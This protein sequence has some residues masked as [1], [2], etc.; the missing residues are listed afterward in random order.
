MATKRKSLGRGLSALLGEDVAA[1][2]GSEGVRKLPVSSLRPGIYQP[3][4]TIDQTAIDELA[5]S[6]RELGVLQPLLVR[7]HPSHPGEFEIIAGERRW[8]AAQQ[9]QLHEV[10]VLLKVI[11]NQEALEIA[12]VENLQR[13][14]L[15]P[16]EEAKGF[17]RLMDE[18]D[19]TQEVLAQAVGKSRSH[20]ANILRLLNLPEA[21]QEL[22]ENGVLSA[23][24]ARALLTSDNAEALAKEV[25]TKGL[26]VRQTE[27]LVSAAAKPTGDGSG[28]T[29][30]VA[31]RDKGIDADTMALQRD[32]SGLLGL[33]VEI[34]AK[35]GK[36][37]LVIHYKN[38]DQLDGLLARLTQGG[39][40]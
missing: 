11:S 34:K 13:R 26:N 23:G 33:N 35:A 6:I 5:A 38:L 18:F 9:A 37:S 31:P 19:H 28:A 36:G 24:H 16:L 27:A 32:L 1:R 8:R 12:L 30:S 2:G 14:D 21:V 3:R 15:S 17:K 40:E 4:L 39:A 10:P 7:E 22:V 29:K 25:V 20:V